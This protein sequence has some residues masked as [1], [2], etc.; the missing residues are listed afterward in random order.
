MVDGEDVGRMRSIEEVVAEI[1]AELTARGAAGRLG[2][3]PIP[4]SMMWTT[5]G[6]EYA[7]KFLNGEAP[8]GREVSY[9]LLASL[10]SDYMF[11]LTG[12]R[13][14]AE[15]N[16]FSVQGR[17]FQNYVLVILGDGGWAATP[18]CKV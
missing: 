7:I 5:V 3:W 18:Q 2:T 15:L 9:E 4:A 14:G 13:I 6:T 1:R 17:S 12:E 16:T 10:M 11:E 8:Q